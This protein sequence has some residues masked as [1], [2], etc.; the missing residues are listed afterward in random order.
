VEKLGTLDFLLGTWE[1]DRS[2]EDH[3]SGTLGSFHGTAVL[4]VDPDEGRP[5]DGRARYDET[6]E[7]TFGAHTGPASRHLLYA[8]GP[9][10]AVVCVS[11]ADGRPFVDLDLS[12]GSWRAV[13]QCGTDRY[14]LTTIVRSRHVVEEHWHVR[15]RARATTPSRPLRGCAAE[16][17]STWR[18]V[19]RRSERAYD[20][21]RDLCAGRAGGTGRAA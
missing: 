14:E 19:R 6:G 12:G 9:G 10:S 7:L 16:L 17:T 2:I 5:G 15:A 20:S 3:R 21:P 4:A 18:D 13:H 1:V 11:F 8:V